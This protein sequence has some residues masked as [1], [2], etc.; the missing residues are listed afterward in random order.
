[1][2]REMRAMEVVTVASTDRM[3]EV[4]GEVDACRGCTFTFLFLRGRTG[5]GG[6]LCICWRWGWGGVLYMGDRWMGIDDA[7][8]MIARET[9]LWLHHGFAGA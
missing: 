8:M 5:R 1:M 3:E 6:G 2:P 9:G 7:L 4:R